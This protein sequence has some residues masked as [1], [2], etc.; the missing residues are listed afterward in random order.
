MNLF[1]SIR[2]NRRGFTLIELLV[3][4]AIIA[5]L[6]ALLL[7]AV[8][9]AREAAR[10]SQCKNNLKQFGLALQNYLDTAKMFP[11]SQLRI[12]PQV[13]NSTPAV[14]WS[15][16]V[17]PFMDQ[18]PLFKSID[19]NAVYNPA[20]QWSGNNQKALE[21]QLPGLRCPSNADPLTVIQ[22]S[23]AP[24]P[25]INFNRFVCN[26]GANAS[27]VVGNGSP[28]GVVA[29][30][31]LPAESQQHLDDAVGTGNRRYDGVMYVQSSTR[32]GDI[33]DGTSS[34]VAVAE[35]NRGGI[36]TR[37]VG[38]YDHFAV[39]DVNPQDESA[40]CNGSFGLP[41][42]FKPIT[43]NSVGPGNP[44]TTAA[45]TSQ[46]NKAGFSSYH[47]GGVHGVLCDGAVK[48]FSEN[49]DQ[50]VSRALG[51]RRGGETVGEY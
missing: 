5:V 46:Q 47:T 13:N 48:F 21:V 35:W 25:V 26:Y 41:L 31:G 4:I 30:A 6:I 37:A 7:P 50:Q 45:Q 49:M 11:A 18:A 10:R 42:N 20:I 40:R 24:M 33:K 36:G 22:T 3:V 17:L 28:P 32:I 29:A 27:G 15:G 9:Q 19:F 14:F 44:G 8:Q 43:N 2:S 38:T 34:T 16:A 12:Q 39:G 1:G 23:A 51:S